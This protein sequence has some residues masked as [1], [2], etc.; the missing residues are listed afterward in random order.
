MQEGGLEVSALQHRPR[1]NQWVSTYWEAF[2][3]LG[4]SRALHQGGVGPIPLSEIVAY[5]DVV[6]LRDVDARLT[7]IKMIQSLDSVYVLHVNEKAEQRAKARRK[8]Q[9]PRKR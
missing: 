8:Q 4:T 9:K 2:Q 1:L 7:F 5:M 3:Y 6:Y